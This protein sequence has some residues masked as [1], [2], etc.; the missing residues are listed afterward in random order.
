MKKKA[1]LPRRFTIPCAKC[2]REF[3]EPLGWFKR[4]KKCPDC[5]GEFN[6]KPFVKILSDFVQNIP[7]PL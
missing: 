1:S 4:K 2:H 7:R 5:G 3:T 6:F